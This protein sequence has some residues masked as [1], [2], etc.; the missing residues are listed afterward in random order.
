[1]VKRQNGS[2]MVIATKYTGGYRSNWQ[3]EPIH[4]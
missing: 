4:S 1:M 2:Q 3:K